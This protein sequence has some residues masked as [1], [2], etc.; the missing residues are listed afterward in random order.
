MISVIKK[1]GSDIDSYTNRGSETLKTVSEITPGTFIKICLNLRKCKKVT[2]ETKEPQN[3]LPILGF[4]FIQEYT[5]I[6][7]RL[8]TMIFDTK[9]Q[10]VTATV[11]FEVSFGLGP[12]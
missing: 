9:N 3:N 2:T 8:S 1:T 7:T 5:I 6:L 12:Y 11:T 10:A 4:S